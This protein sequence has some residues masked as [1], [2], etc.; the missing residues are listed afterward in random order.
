MDLYSNSP[1]WLL[2]NGL[3]NSYP[4]VAKNYSTE[5]VIMGA[6]ISGALMGYH[7]KEAGFDFMIV[8]RRHVGMGSTAASTALI[9][10]EIDQPL[11][12]LIGKVGEKNALRSYQLS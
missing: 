8:D 12:K 1:Y 11:R 9:Q 10:Y 3:L 5:V 7:L 4:S 2:K 6:G